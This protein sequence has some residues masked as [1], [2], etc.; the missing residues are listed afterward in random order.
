MKKILAILLL[1]MSLFGC[2]KQDDPTNGYIKCNSLEEINKSA[3]VEIFKPAIMGISNE[4]YF[5]IEQTT[6]SYTFD[7]NGYMYNIR[8]SKDLDFDM[9]GIFTNTVEPL[10]K[11]LDEKIQYGETDEYKAYRFLLGNSQYI[12]S[13]QDNGQMDKKLFESQFEDVFKLFCVEAS[14]EEIKNCVGTY[15]DSTS[16]RATMEIS[17]IDINELYIDITWPSS[18][19][20]YDE[21]IITVTPTSRKVEYED[22]THKR[23]VV[24]ENG[25]S[26][27]TTLDDYTRGYFE[28]ENGIVRWTGSGND[29]TSSCVFEKV[30]IVN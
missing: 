9:S 26:K 29:Q 16:Q 25:N 15:Q 22:I 3:N 6:A 2:Q 12:F 18:A 24:D 14:F 13:V 17:L 30:E 23:V 27:E 7:A 20:E 19:S 11:H 21:W 4:R 10:F 8:G 1:S 5:L 28:I